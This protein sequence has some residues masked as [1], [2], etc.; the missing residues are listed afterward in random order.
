MD[1]QLRLL[2]D[3]ILAQRENLGIEYVIHTGDI[4]DEF[5]EEYEFQNAS[6]ELKK[7]EDAGLPY[8]VLGGNHDVAHGNERY[9]LY[10]KYFGA[11]RY[12]EFPWYGGSYENNLGHYDLVSVDGQELLF[13]YMSW[14]IYT[15]EVEWINS[16][17]EQYPRA[18]RHHLHPRRH[19]RLGRA[20]LSERAA[21]GAGG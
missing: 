18:H 8:G 6:K 9:G 20:Q 5:N 3:Y 1:G 4:V 17:L 15:D 10:W 14:D 12:E 16:V 19:Q 11:D 7:F 13:I 21:H 2:T